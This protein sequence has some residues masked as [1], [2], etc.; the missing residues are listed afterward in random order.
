VTYE[1]AVENLSESEREVTG[2]IFGLAGYLAHDDY[3]NVPFMLLDSLKVIDSN[4]IAKI[5]E[6]LEEVSEYL[7][8]ALLEED[9]SGLDSRYHTILRF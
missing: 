6:Y 4:R 8:V 2:L 5:V 9:A 3:G 7:V 1:D